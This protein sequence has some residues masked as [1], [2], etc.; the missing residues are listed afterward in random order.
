VALRRLF[1]GRHS[2]V[3]QRPYLAIVLPPITLASVNATVQANELQPIRRCCQTDARA[4]LR[5]LE[6]ATIAVELTTGVR[7]ADASMTG[8]KS[9]VTKQ[10]NGFTSNRTPDVEVT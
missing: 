7:S 3:A 4:V 2:H 6:G 5:R 8:T 9:T 1:V 10:V